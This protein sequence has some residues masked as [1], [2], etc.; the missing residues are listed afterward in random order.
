[1]SFDMKSVKSLLRTMMCCAALAACNTEVNAPKPAPAELTRD[2]TGYFCGM[3]VADHR[4]PKSQVILRGTDET[5]WFTSARDGI[6]FKRLPE[7]TRPISVFY[8]SAVD[9][10]GWE[11]PESD[12]GNWVEAQLAWYVIESE[13]RGGMGAA[14]AIPFAEREAARAFADEFGGRV[15]GLD[16]IPNSYILGP[17]S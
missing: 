11:H 14:E 1:M 16:E 8:V 6:A 15:L 10:G 5:L 7:E 9:R 4:G 2:D 13:K 12:P 3:I 17:G